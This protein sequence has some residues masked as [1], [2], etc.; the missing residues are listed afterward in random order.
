LETTRR[1]NLST[2]DQVLTYFTNLLLDGNMSDEERNILKA[3]GT[4]DTYGSSRVVDEKLRSLV[5]LIMASP[6]YQLA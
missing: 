4:L 6:D 2:A 1:L 3:F 5:Y